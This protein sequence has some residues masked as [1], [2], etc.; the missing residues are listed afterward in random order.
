MDNHQAI[1]QTQ[2]SHITMGKNYGLPPTGIP[3]IP[4][5]PDKMQTL[6]ACV[7]CLSNN[8]TW[9]RVKIIKFQQSWVKQK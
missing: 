7:K 8:I 9:K 5:D 3:Y 2:H 4:N 6:H 1:D